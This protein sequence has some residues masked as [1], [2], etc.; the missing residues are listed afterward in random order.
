MS[1]S[2]EIL[3]FIRRSSHEFTTFQ[4]LIL[5]ETDKEK[6]HEELIITQINN[7]L[8]KKNSCVNGLKIIHYI[9]PRISDE[10]LLKYGLLWITKSIQILGSI[11]NNISDLTFTC[12]TLADLVVLCKNKPELHKQISMQNVKQ[13][14][15]ILNNLSEKER[16][17]GVYYLIAVLLF[18][19]AEVCERHQDTIMKM[20]LP[21]I[22][23]NEVN[24]ATAGA[25]CFALITKALE[26]SFK[27]PTKFVN[28]NNWVYSQVLLCNSLHLIINQLFSDVSEFIFI[29]K[30]DFEDYELLDLPKISEDNILEYYNGLE[31]RFVNLNIYLSTMLRGCGEKN[32]VSPTDILHL[33]CKGL[34]ITPFNLKSQTSVETI[35]LSMLPRLHVSLLTTTCAFIQGFKQELIPFSDS[36]LKLIQQTLEWTEKMTTNQSISNQDES[37]KTVRLFAYK[38]LNAWLTYTGSVTVIETFTNC[39]L[40]L[41]IKDIKGLSTS[42][43]TVQNQHENN[44]FRAFNQGLHTLQFNTDACE[45][46]LLSLQNILLSANCWLNSSSYELIKNQIVCVLQDL[47]LDSSLSKVLKLKANFR[48][49]LLKTMEVMQMNFHPLTPPPTQFSAEIFNMALIDTDVNVIQEAKFGVS[50][51]EKIIHPGAPTLNLPFTS[52]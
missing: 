3:N 52:N 50:K 35:L 7:E 31:R 20:I 28:Y 11:E 15:V 42:D 4:N 37:F 19:Y 29:D 14:L 27:P 21:Q 18:H 49:Q 47:Y 25:N 13:I 10:N 6:S 8:K 33:L 16:C 36:I 30:M 43:L 17:G 32:S 39:F 44:S 51:L 12:Q 26:R 46:A 24:L 22:D 5:L 45:E 23:S 2:T 38:T 41:I 34:A 1:N 9:L 48:L 40:P